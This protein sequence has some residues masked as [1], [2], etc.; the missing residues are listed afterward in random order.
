M[1]KIE[2][3]SMQGEISPP[4]EKFLKLQK[5]KN[6]FGICSTSVGDEKCTRSQSLEPERNF[7]LEKNPTNQ[8]EKQTTTSRQEEL[9]LVLSARPTV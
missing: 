6:C 5:E 9:S 4:E 3:I 2:K 8:K 1:A 7:Q